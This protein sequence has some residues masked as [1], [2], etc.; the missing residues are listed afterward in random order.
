MAYLHF[1]DGS[2]RQVSYDQAA[3]VHQILLGNE[4]PQDETQ[5]Q[6]VEQVANVEFEPTVATQSRHKGFDAP[7]PKLHALMDD[8]TLTGREK[9]LAIGNHLR[10]RQG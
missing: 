5:A 2:K 10:E 6:F 1:S 7:D 3:K 8:K 4:L 9:F